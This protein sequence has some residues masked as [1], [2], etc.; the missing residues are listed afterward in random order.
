MVEKQI[1]TQKHAG[2]LAPNSLPRNLLGVFKK[3]EV[4]CR[5]LNN[6]LDRQI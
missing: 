1:A 3:R 4:N 5:Q 2:L 6:I